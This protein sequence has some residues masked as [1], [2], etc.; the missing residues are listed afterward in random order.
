MRYTIR[1]SFLN[2]AR[3]AMALSFAALPGETAFSAPAPS[4]NR[5][6]ILL[7][8]SDDHS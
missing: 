8:L 7:I 2:P 4:G 5:P 3:F 1:N 6:N